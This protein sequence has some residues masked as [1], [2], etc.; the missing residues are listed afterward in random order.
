MEK[1]AAGVWHHYKDADKAY[2]VIGEARNVTNGQEDQVMVVY[3]EPVFEGYQLCV[4]RK[5]EFLG[6]V[7]KDSSSQISR[8]SYD[9]AATLVA[10]SPLILLNLQDRLSLIPSL[11]AFLGLKLTE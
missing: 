10:Y 8:F 6:Q 2:V 5:E 7:Q 4:Q 9:K 1:A 11:A 3:L